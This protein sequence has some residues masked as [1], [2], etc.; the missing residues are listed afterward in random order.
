MS[1]SLLG[2]ET[3]PSISSRGLDTVSPQALGTDIEYSLRSNTLSAK[4]VLGGR[5]ALTSSENGVAYVEKYGTVS[6]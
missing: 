1:W 2:L 6:S 3:C 5:V 4:S